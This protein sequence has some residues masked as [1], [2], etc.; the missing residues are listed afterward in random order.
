MFGTIEDNWA[1]VLPEDFQPDLGVTR[2]RVIAGD[3]ASAHDVVPV[4]GTELFGT[5]VK[6]LV[7]FEAGGSAQD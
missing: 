3:H 1:L 2:R 7:T 4:L 6:V 5:A